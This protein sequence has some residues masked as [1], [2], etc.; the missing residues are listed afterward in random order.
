MQ[1]YDGD[2]AHDILVDGKWEGV[3]E[4]AC[5]KGAVGF[6][7]KHFALLSSNVLAHGMRVISF[8]D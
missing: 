8:V 2:S 5:T 7:S 1:Y 4:M 3:W 6:R